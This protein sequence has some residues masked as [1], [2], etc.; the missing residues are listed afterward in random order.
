MSDLPDSN[1]LPID[2]RPRVR[3]AKGQEVSLGCGTLILIAIIVLT[4]SR[5]GIGDVE[6]QVRGLRTDVGNEV[7]GLRTEMDELKKAIES[8]T[9]Q[10]KALQDKLDRPKG[11]K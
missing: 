11:D 8:Q 4:F 9:N 10:I 2:Q 7:R 1:R 3:L 5:S 6:D